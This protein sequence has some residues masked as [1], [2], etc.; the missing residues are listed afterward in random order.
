METEYITFTVTAKINYLVTQ[1]RQPSIEELK[2]KIEAV[3][4]NWIACNG[5]VLNA[6]E[7]PE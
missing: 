7:S 1:D 5:E 2:A 4:F 3:E 6:W